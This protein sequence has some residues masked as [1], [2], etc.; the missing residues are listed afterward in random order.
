MKKGASKYFAPFLSSHDVMEY[1]CSV[2]VYETYGM[3]LNE[4]F[5]SCLAFF[6][7]VIL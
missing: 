3:L 4:T 1:G 7:L 5:W 2:D 6:V